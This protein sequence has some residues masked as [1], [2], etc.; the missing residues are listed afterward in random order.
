MIITIPFPDSSLN[1]NRK[2]G[3]H[4][5]A[6]KSAK[7]SYYQHAYYASR[8]ALGRDKLDVCDTYKLRL[9]F[10]QPDKRLR[11]LDNLFSS[12]KSAIDGI[13]SALKINDRQFAAVELLRGYHK[14][15]G[16]VL[17]WIIRMEE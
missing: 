2:N 8:E 7:D 11:D 10:I 4:W 6:T 13:A 1:P 15:K 17:V 9:T 12:C 14:D 5:A 16:C 3:R